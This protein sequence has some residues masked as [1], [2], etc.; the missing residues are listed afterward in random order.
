MS[1]PK[2]L[3]SAE[4]IPSLSSDCSFLLGWSRLT[5]NFLSFVGGSAICSVYGE[6]IPVKELA[7]RVASYVHL[8]TLY[9]WL[10]FVCTAVCILTIILF[11]KIIKEISVFL[12]SFF[13]HICE[14][15]GV[16]A[17][18]LLDVG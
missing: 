14:T 1:Q 3:Y 8:C 2:I 18:G 16:L 12:K 15:F 17:T 13:L 4:K 10:R 5:P 6:P 7:E 11:V 9:W